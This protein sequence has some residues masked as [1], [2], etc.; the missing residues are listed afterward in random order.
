MNQDV[1]LNDSMPDK[2]ARNWAMASHL[3]PLAGYFFPIPFCS[4]LGPLIIWL[5]KK[6]ESAFISD[7]AKEAMNF[8]LTITIAYLIS[9]ALIFVLIGFFLIG[10]VAIYALVMII[11][12]AIKASEGEHY[13]YPYCIRFIK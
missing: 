12:A 10:V 1:E 13:R 7:Q 8:Q 5:I 6:D 4:L 9:L 11:I 2:E 3:S